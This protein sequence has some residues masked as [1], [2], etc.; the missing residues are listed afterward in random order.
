MV[1]LKKLAS[2][3]GDAKSQFVRIDVDENSDLLWVAFSHV[4]VPVGK[5]AQT[6]ALRRLAGNKIYLNCK[7]NAWYGHGVESISTD[8]ETTMAWLADI[9][10]QYNTCFVGHSMGA[11][12]SMLAGNLI[13]G[14]RFV[15]TSPEFHL[16]LSGSRA[17][18]NDVSV[19]Q[20]WDSVRSLRHLFHG[21]PRGHIFMGVYDPIDAYFVANRELVKDMGALQ[22]VPHHHGVTEFFTS[23]GIYLDIL[24][25]S[26]QTFRQLEV[27]GFLHQPNTFG[28]PEQYINFYEVFIAFQQK[29]FNDEVLKRIEKDRNWSNPGWQELCSKVFRAMGDIGLACKSAAN[30]FFFQPTVPEYYDEYAKCLIEAKSRLGVIELIS[31]TPQKLRTHNVYR[32]LTAKLSQPNAFS[33]DA[34]IE[35]ECIFET[36]SFP[37][38]TAHP[39]DPRTVPSADELKGL[40][41]QSRWVDILELTSVSSER[42]SQV[43]RERLCWHR[44]IALEHVGELGLLFRH[45]RSAAKDFP[46]SRKIALQILRVGRSHH[47]PILIWSFLSMNLKGQQVDGF[48]LNSIKECFSFIR[49]PRLAGR[50][51]LFVLSHAQHVEKAERVLSKKMI[52]EGL[53]HSVTRE[54]LNEATL[55]LI[56]D[57]ALV[58]FVRMAARAGFR[59]TVL[60]LI[61]SGKVVKSRGESIA[62]AV[63]MLRKG[64]VN[65]VVRLF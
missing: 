11:Y 24:A 43:E 16:N 2:Q 13:P 41:E 58:S 48:I 4:D 51:V 62:A 40:R 30:S 1:N 42:L 37:E 31:A 52:G 50:I 32:N 45:L 61:Q 7:N 29:R 59:R 63:R 10:G 44:G 20:P 9:C 46:N 36:S 60:E 39:V 23:N 33:Q 18:R 26:D 14:T 19:L 27:S 55:S 49:N 38:G 15:A 25:G 6:N 28:S 21:A 54:L 47:S 22:E 57:R 5:F 12:M 65:S 56:P 34:G 17:V 64:M 53:L 3:I 35:Y 8:I